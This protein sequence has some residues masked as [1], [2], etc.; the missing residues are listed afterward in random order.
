MLLVAFVI[1]G[2]GSKDQRTADKQT[3]GH[4]VPEKVPDGTYTTRGEV[5]SLPVKGD[6]RTSFKVRHEAIDGFR[7]RKGEVVGMNAMTMDFPP[8]KGVD[9]SSLKVGDK[10]EITFSVWWG[11]TP[12]W[13]ATKVSKLPADTELVYRK[14]RPPESEKKG[15][16]DEN[17][18]VEK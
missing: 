3:E 8:A 5:V 16:G 9:L 2:C 13:L 1:V 12:P 6:V 18:P 11:N 17:V 14:A 15:S 4:S 10:V 7:N